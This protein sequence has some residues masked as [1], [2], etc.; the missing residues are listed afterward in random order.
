VL[1]LVDVVNHFKISDG[2]AI[3][4][5]ALQIA[6]R[7]ARLKKRARDSNIPVVGATTRRAGLLRPQTHAFGVFSDAAGSVA[8]TLRRLVYYP[9]GD[10]HEQLRSMHGA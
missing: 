7:L 8:P 2:K 10:C 4:K 3:V 6:P 5:N 9:R 1:L